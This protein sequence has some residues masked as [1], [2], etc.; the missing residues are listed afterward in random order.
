RRRL[1]IGD[2]DEPDALRADPFGLAGDGHDR[3]PT[4]RRTTRLQDP[5]DAFEKRRN[6][7][8]Y[9]TCQHTRNP[10]VDRP[11]WVTSIWGS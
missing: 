5:P 2:L 9:D 8:I 1:G 10:F 11:E 6:Q 7:V 3:G 4:T